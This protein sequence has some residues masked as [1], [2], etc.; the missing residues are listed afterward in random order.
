MSGW[1]F[2]GICAA[3]LCAGCVIAG[4]H[5]F[6]EYRS[7]P[8]GS[9][10]G[11]V[12]EQDF[13]SGDL[14]VF[15]SFPGY[16]IGK[17][18]YNGSPGL[19]AERKPGE[20]YG[21]VSVC[22]PNL[23][24]GKTY[25][26]SMLCRGENIQGEPHGFCLE[27]YRRDNGQYAGGL[28]DAQPITSEWKTIERP[29][30]MKGNVDLRISLYIRDKASGTLYYD[31]LRVEEVGHLWSVLPTSLTGLSLWT[32]DSSFE[33]KAS[34]PPGSSG[35]DYPVLAT[36]DLEGKR[37]EKLLIPDERGFCTGDF[38]KLPAGKGKI[39][40]TLLDRKRQRRLCA[41][42]YAIQVRPRSAASS[43]AVTIDRHHRLI[44]DGKPFMPIGIYAAWRGSVRDQDLKRIADAGFNTVHLYGMAW[45]RGPGKH[46]SD[47][48]GIRAG[49]DQVHRHGL[50]LIASIK[51]HLHGWNHKVDDAFGPIPVVKKIVSNLKDHPAILVWY[52]SDEEARSRIP[53]IVKLRETVGAIDPDHPTCTLTCFYDDLAQYATSGDILGIDPYPIKATHGPQSLRELQEALAAGEKT[54]ITVW[55][56]PQAFNWAVVD[57]NMSDEAFRKTRF[58][59]R[60]EV[61]TAPLLGAVYGAKGFV[62]YAYYDIAEME[63][64]APERGEQ[65]WNN[66]RETVQVL[67]D[68]E[69]YI[70]STE[71]APA[72]KVES[73]PA[74]E[75]YAR[76]FTKDGKTRVAIT[77]IGRKCKAVITVPGCADLKSR[78]GKT[79]SLGAS[80]YEFAADAVDSDILE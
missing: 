17:W 54:G 41:T 68:L 71:S 29:F 47:M 18:G 60:E 58:L 42:A 67:R 34:L 35:K 66:L 39:D 63:R 10:D 26:V 5:S 74:G 2:Y 32:D 33:L 1:N 70:M 40:F 78:F 77:S 52:V 64:R 16:S 27:F 31:N 43:N 30:T 38:G 57:R 56:V 79:R 37:Y 36:L 28:Y 8:S 20:K 24:A 15:T 50:K 19:R 55:H 61:R 69:P 13:A 22:I 80:R 21:F 72:V 59:T 53:D 44:V 62:F 46:A 65:D 76:A 4:D 51:E 75:V 25:K 73:A 45:H 9:G 48:A 14:K 7:W 11:V 6:E 12:Y 49:V 3:F 23:K